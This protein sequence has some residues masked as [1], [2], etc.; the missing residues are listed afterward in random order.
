MKIS[1]VRS[2]TAAAAGLMFVFSALGL[3]TA[4]G[5]AEELTA[6]QW[7]PAAQ[8]DLG[9]QFAEAPVLELTDVLPGPTRVF[10]ETP[11]WAPNA[12]GQSWDGIFIYQSAYFGRKEVVIHDFGS[13]ETHRQTLST[14]GGETALT[15]AQFTAHIRE[16]F[17]VDGKLFIQVLAD[18]P[19]GGGWTLMVLAYDPA[20]NRFVHASLPFGDEIV[21]AGRWVLGDDGMIYGLGWTAD[22]RAFIPYRIDPTTFE[23]KRYA[24]FGPANEHR[25]QMYMNAVMVGDWLYA[26][27]GSRPWRLVGYNF[28]E[29]RGRV[30]ATTKPI[31]GDHRT[32]WVGLNEHG[33]AARVRQPAEI[34]DLDA[35][36]PEETNIWINDGRVY[37][38]EQADAT[39]PWPDVQTFR[40]PYRWGGPTKSLEHQ[41]QPAP[42]EVDRHSMTP[43][44]EGRV[45][46]RYRPQDSES[47]QTVAF[48]VQRYPGVVRRL[49]EIDDHRL[50][51]TDESYGQA[52][53]FDLAKQQT[54]R[55]GDLADLSVYSLT[56][57]G[58]KVYAAGYPSCRLYEFDVNRP[59]TLE[60]YAPAASPDEV[61]VPLNPR[62]LAVMMEHN[63]VHTPLGGTHV[64]ADGRVYVGG[65]AV[66]RRYNGGG[67]GWYDTKTGEVGGVW[68]PFSAQRIYWMCTAD[69]GRYIV[70]TT[71]PTQDDQN[72]AFTP[73][74]GLM[75][76]WDTKTH[77]FTHQI[78][79]PDGVG[80]FE[81]IAAA[82]DG[83]VMSYTGAA[84]YGVDID[85]G[86][87]LWSKPVPAATPGSFAAVRRHRYAFRRGPDGAIWALMGAR[88]P[89]LVRINPRTAHVEVLGRLPDKLGPAQLA[90]CNG[91]VYL[92]G[93]AY[94]RRIEGVRYK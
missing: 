68:K 79:P 83:L 2:A 48:D 16:A 39:P 36:N 35:F 51:A 46:L 14:G 44:A 87:V 67:L 93:S 89:V 52:V 73:D 92:A 49:V 66:G 47:W 58:D 25:R 8:E 32:I 17:F 63:H 72:P 78:A 61:P 7:R 41:P 77:E 5:A 27:V 31:L 90:F 88:A 59:F 13:G 21:R 6:H 45:E 85:A 70:S 9:E 23:V 1:K 18:A 43:N 20:Q 15:S 74:Q 80:R 30:L 84:L 71:K 26:K 57:H 55:I 62:E 38:R 4:A 50:F 94:L 86:K 91:A 11:Y 40:D 75:F 29:Q 28:A 19:I 54:L 60:Q 10:Y 3:P 42:P 76:V 65:L 12:D 64:G 24:A 81:T 69:E 33:V 53:I 56:A 22:N 37:P 82:G 34:A